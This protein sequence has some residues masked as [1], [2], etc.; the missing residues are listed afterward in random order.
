MTNGVIR[1]RILGALSVVQVLLAAWLVIWIGLLIYHLW[2][3]DILRPR[4]AN[5][6][7]YYVVTHFGSLGTSL[8]VSVLLICAI[9]FAKWLLR[10]DR[11]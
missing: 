2:I 3:A 1:G 8:Y 4:W 6:D 5:S 11:S 10:R 9:A 7:T